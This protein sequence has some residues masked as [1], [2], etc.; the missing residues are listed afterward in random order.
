MFIEINDNTTINTN[1]ITMVKTIQKARPVAED[2][3]TYA[4][5]VA[6]DMSYQRNAKTSNSKSVTTYTIRFICGLELRTKTNILELLN[7]Q[8]L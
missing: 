3:E 8:S 6:A 4:E 5:Y 1:N 2:Y 7:D